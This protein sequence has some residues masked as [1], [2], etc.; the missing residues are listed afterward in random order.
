MP[1]PSTTARVLLA[2]LVL[3]A[4]CACGRP[5]I[6]EVGLADDAVTPAPRATTPGSPGRLFAIRTDLGYGH[7]PPASV[8]STARAEKRSHVARAVDTAEVRPVLPR[9]ARWPVFA[10]MGVV[11]A[12]ALALLAANLWGSARLR[13]RANLAG[14]AIAAAFVVVFALAALLH[15]PE[16]VVDN[17]TA[18]SVTVLLDGRQLVDLPPRT[19]VRARYPAAGVLVEVRGEAGP[20]ESARL[21]RPLGLADRLRQ[22]V[23]LETGFAYDVRG[24]NR[25]TVAVATYR[26]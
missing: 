6:E 26:E 23:G 3:L 4:C 20:V 21:P 17:A 9:R 10:G 13:R 11:L 1:S 16:L 22:G 19:F 2:S 14:L 18:E 5:G 7:T 15:D 12:G 25:Y 24:A 8:S